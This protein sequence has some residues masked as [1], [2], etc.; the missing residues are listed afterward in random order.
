MDPI[1]IL[2]GVALFVSMAANF[3]GSKK[4][5]K[6]KVVNVSKRPKSYLQKVPLN[7]SALI[8]IFEILGVFSIGTLDYK[9]YDNY[10]FIRIIGLVMFV[11]FSWL[12]TVSFKTLGEYYSTEV[13]VY[14][15]HRLITSGIYKS[16]RHPQYLFQVLSDIGAGLALL[17]FLVLPA[18]IFILLPLFILR[19][20][21]ED[22][23]LS[24]VFNKDWDEYKKGS[25]FFL[26]F[27]G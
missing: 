10:N 27:L 22:N 24:E 9:A 4:G 17:S 20:K 19:A 2:F 1:N 15:S 26:P 8:I 5:M 16:V 23:L 12:Q 7:V 6:G 25:G 3:S 14:K 21:L 11:V 18:V 13:A